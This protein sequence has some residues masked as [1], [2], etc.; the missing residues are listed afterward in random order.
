MSRT[1]A[2]R[3]L[4][5]RSRLERSIEA[6]RHQVTGIWFEPSFGLLSR[7]RSSHGVHEEVTPMSLSFR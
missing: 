4:R 1:L 2:E 3:P 5:P 6:Q 7:R